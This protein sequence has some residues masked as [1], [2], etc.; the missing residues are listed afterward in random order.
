[1]K[2]SEHW[3]T[4]GD[5][6][7]CGRVEDGMPCEEEVHGL[8]TNYWAKTRIYLC[9]KHIEENR[10]YAKKHKLDITEIR[11]GHLQ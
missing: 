2:G 6:D 4:L 1:M 3:P 9:A 5:R 7:H 10:Q 8:F 11:E